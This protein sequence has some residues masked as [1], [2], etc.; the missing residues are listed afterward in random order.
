VR[1][2]ALCQQF[3]EEEEGQWGN[4]KLRRVV[5]VWCAEAELACCSRGDDGGPCCVPTGLP[6]RR[7]MARRSRVGALKPRRRR[8]TMPCVADR[9]GPLEGQVSPRVFLAIRAFFSSS[10]ARGRSPGSWVRPRIAR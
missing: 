3:V 10:G 7:V 6:F 2:C 4:I 1:E 9:T 5:A 8:L